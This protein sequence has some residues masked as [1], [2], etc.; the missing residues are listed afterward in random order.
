MEVV[1]QVEELAGL[2]RR[3]AGDLGAVDR[4]AEVLGRAEQLTAKQAQAV[5]FGLREP[6]A[7]IKTDAAPVVGQ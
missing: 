1:P 3:Q 4:A 5:A 2:D 6:V 7:V